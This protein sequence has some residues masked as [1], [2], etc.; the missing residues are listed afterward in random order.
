VPCLDVLDVSA[1]A[2][3]PC[4]QAANLRLLLNA[5]VYPGM[6]VQLMPSNVGVTFGVVN[7]AS[8]Q[9]RGV[10]RGMDAEALIPGLVLLRSARLR[11]QGPVCPSSRLGLLPEC[12]LWQ[13]AHL[14]QLV[15][16]C[17]PGATSM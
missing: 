13:L 6:P 1:D 17:S 7:A 8:T 14:V 4:L 11:L 15:A 12:N 10:M 5:K 2:A 16:T 9:V 3:R